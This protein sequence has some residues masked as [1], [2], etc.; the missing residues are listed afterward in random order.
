MDTG[1]RLG[2]GHSRVQ[3]DY[4]YFHSGGAAAWCYLEIVSAMAYLAQA[5]VNMG[6]AARNCYDQSTNEYKAACSTDINGLMSSL[7]D[8]VSFTGGAAS[9]CAKT[10]NNAGLC[11]GD[12]GTLGNALG[13]LGAASSSFQYVCGKKTGARLFAAG[14]R[15]LSLSEV[16]NNTVLPAK[17]R[18]VLRRLSDR[19]EIPLPESVGDVLI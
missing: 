2:T 16:A 15:R 3:N 11:A 9:I 19:L 13:G 17:L 6:A 1:R 7:S 18:A 5:G 4:I 14:S 8:V 10:L 12:V